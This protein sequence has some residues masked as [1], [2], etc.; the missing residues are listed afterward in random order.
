M[1]KYERQIKS[2]KRKHHLRPILE[3]WRQLQTQENRKHTSTV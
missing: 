2:V 3:I 1:M